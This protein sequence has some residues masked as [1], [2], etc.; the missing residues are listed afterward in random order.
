METTKIFGHEFTTIATFKKFAYQHNIIPIGNKSL[1]ATW[2]EA[3]T[4]YLSAQSNAIAMV[5]EADP[6]ASEI[7]TT[8][9]NTAV[10]I[11]SLAIAI[12]TSETAVLI[13]R[14]VIKT[15]AFAIV[16]AW[17]LTVVAVKW[18][19]A[20]RS[21]T[22]VYHWIKDA[23]GSEFTQSAITYLV[24]G[25]WVLIE[26]I[27]SIDSAISSTVGNSREWLDGLIAEARSIVG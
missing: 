25:E 19:W 6:I 5:V 12:L 2:V 24:L 3:V 22:A 18:C 9:E 27:D 16:M 20:H 15:I 11:G 26:W 14:V 13:Y 1:K 8:V 23:A 21:S 17:L 4:L 7:A 10:S